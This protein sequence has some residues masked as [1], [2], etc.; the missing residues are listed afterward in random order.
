MMS[1][2]GASSAYSQTERWLRGPGSATGK[3]SKI[4]ADCIKAEDGIRDF[5]L[6]RGLGDVYKRQMLA[7]LSYLMM[8]ADLIPDLLPVAGFS[9]DLV[10]LTAMVGLCSNHV[11]QAIW[12]RA[13]RKLGRCFPLAH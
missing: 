3:D 11:T 13:R 1:V 6:S 10:A 9:D 4:E 12:M 2:L 7:A 8:P 5:C